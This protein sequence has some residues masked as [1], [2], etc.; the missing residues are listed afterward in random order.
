[1]AL[2][3][4]GAAATTAATSSLAIPVIGI[5]LAAT[6]ATLGAIAAS[7]TNAKIRKRAR[8]LMR[9]VNKQMSQVQAEAMDAV[10][11]RSTIGSMSIAAARNRFGFQTTGLSVAERLASLAGAL[12]VDTNAI[13]FAEDARLEALRTQKVDISREARGLQTA[14]LEAAVSGLVG[15]FSAGLTLDTALNQ[16][17]SAGDKS[18]GFKILSNITGGIN[19]I[20]MLAFPR[21]FESFNRQLSR[22]IADTDRQISLFQGIEGFLNTGRGGR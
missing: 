3:V 14:P 10:R 2:F 19:Q 22:T 13:N 4:A 6:F 18:E 17:V 5:F 21:T 1:M 20:Q 16:L 9:R 7:S 15:G 12:T 8:E 11:R